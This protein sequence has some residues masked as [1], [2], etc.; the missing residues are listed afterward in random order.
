M[1]LAA[2]AYAFWDHRKQS[3]RLVTL[4]TP[5]AEA[6]GGSVKPATLLALPQLRFDHEG[7]NYFIGA[8]ANAGNRVSGSASRPGFTGAFS[9]ANVEI[10]RDT[11]QDL[12]ILRTDRLDRAAIRVIGSVSK[13]SLSTSGDSAFD[14]AFRIKSKDQ[15]FVN[16]IVSPELRQML[17][18]SPQQRLEVNLKGSTISVH[19]D[20]YVKSAAQL[21]EMIGIVTLLA[22][23]CEA[24]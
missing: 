15:A 16:H 17:L 20:D 19:I 12:N 24:S 6:Y 23:T 1:V 11:G 7:R 22:K 10:E 13:T 8:M 5:I 9:F 2:L 3:N 18:N 4:F 14:S 21:D